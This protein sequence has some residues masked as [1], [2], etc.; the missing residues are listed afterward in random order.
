MMNNNYLM[1]QD[2][3]SGGVYRAFI[4][5]RSDS[6]VFIPGLCDKNILDSN[7]DISNEEFE[8][9]KKTLPLALYNSPEIEK[10]LDDKPTPCF[11]AF[12]NGNMKRPI[13]IGYFG[14]G[15]KSVPGSGGYSSSSSGSD[16]SYIGIENPTG[17]NYKIV[18]RVFT[19]DWLQANCKTRQQYLDAVM[20]TFKEYCKNNDHQVVLKYPGVLALQPFF[21]VNA[22]FPQTL[23]NVAKTDNN[24]GGLKYS[25]KIPGASVGSKV[26]SN[27]TGGNYCRFENISA[28]FYAQVWNATSKTYSLAQN[29]QSSMEDFTRTFL[30]MW[31]K[32]VSGTGANSYSE[33][34]ISEYKKYN[35]FKYEN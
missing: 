18:D 8:K 1:N 22:N 6:R 26:P 21:E 23:S 13:V 25:S 3:M 28:Y 33:S 34:L 16:D 19:L 27:E 30:N 15:V 11:V 2:F 9:V 12:E 4:I 5:K 24:L 35:L 20:P 29:H 31:V 10:L 14:K 17:S 32:G 7:G